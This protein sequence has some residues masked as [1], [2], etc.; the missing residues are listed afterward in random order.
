MIV[1]SDHS[2]SY[3]RLPYLLRQ[4]DLP[5]QTAGGSTGNY[6]GSFVSLDGQ[7]TYG[8]AGHTN[9]LVSLW[10]HGSAPH[11]PVV[12]PVWQQAAR[13]LHSSRS[14]VRRTACVPANPAGGST[15]ALPSPV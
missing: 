14:S 9:E 3:L 4:G 7:G 12:K 11:Q 15:L 10:M 6:G 13:A 8:S 5:T 1:F 2:N